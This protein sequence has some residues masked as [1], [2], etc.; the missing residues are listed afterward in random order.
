ML[1]FFAGRLRTIQLRRR[2]ALA[3]LL[4]LVPLAPLVGLDPLLISVALLASAAILSLPSGSPPAADAAPPSLIDSDRAEEIA[5]DLLTRAR[6][7]R[8]NTACMMIS[9]SG[10]GL[11]KNQWET[12]QARNAR[13]LCLR[14]IQGA[15]RTRDSAMRIGDALFIA[16]IEPAL[17]LDLEAQ[18]KIAARIQSALEEPARVNGEDHVFRCAIGFCGSSRLPK[19]ACGDELLDAVRTALAEAEAE[20]PSIIRAWS[21]GVDANHAMRRIIRSEAGHAL[22]AGQVQPWFQPQICTSTG[23]ISGVEALARWVHP[24]R[25]VIS[26]G[27]FLPAL[28][29]AGR[30]E[31]LGEIMLD[32]ALEALTRWDEAGIE[33]PRVSVNL[34]MQELRNPRLVD[35]LSWAL[36]RHDLAP[37]RIGLEILETVV[38]ENCSCDIA[39]NVSALAELGCHID[40]DDFGTGRAAI[41][42]LRSLSVHRL[43]IDRSFVT[44]ADRDDDQRRLVC[45]IVSLADQLG[46][47]TLAEGVESA[48]EH[49]TLAQLGCDHVQGF[50]IARPLPAAQFVAW[51]NEHA[52]RLM[53]TVNIAPL[54]N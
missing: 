22:E 38:A 41:S 52:Q 28:E 2:S 39:R 33:V 43:K 54:R 16:F 44:R 4:V 37:S 9:V 10:L 20:G 17:R 1:Q 12:A 5:N 40:L 14:R 23:R 53:P 25:G 19:D 30:I 32:H 49:T 15:L 46:L 51:A 48:G 11:E 26:P 35:R 34:S 42:T 18:L 24:D 31:H 27:Q 47:E 3:G 29:A 21:D 7:E 13:D 50:G 36:D 6:S 45:A 8:L